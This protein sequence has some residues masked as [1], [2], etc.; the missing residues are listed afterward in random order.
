[1]ARGRQSNRPARCAASST[2][3]RISSADS[4]SASWLAKCAVV[5][6]SIE[7]EVNEKKKHDIHADSQGNAPHQPRAHAHVNNMYGMTSVPFVLPLHSFA[8][9]FANVSY[10]SN[11][12]TQGE[13][14]RGA[15]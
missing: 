4:F 1:M 6:S 3:H 8:N 13:G 11:R 9:I 7:S 14:A 2:K 10:R 5:Q 12:N 15:R